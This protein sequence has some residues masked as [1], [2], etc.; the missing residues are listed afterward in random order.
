MFTS[1][2]DSPPKALVYLRE[3]ALVAHLDGNGVLVNHL[4]AIALD[5]TRK[6]YESKVLPPVSS[7]AW[8]VV[9]SLFWLTDDYM[10]REI[11]KTLKDVEG[12]TKADNELLKLLRVYDWLVRQPLDFD[13]DRQTSDLRDISLEWAGEKNAVELEVLLAHVVELLWYRSPFGDW[14]QIATK[15][16]EGTFEGLANR[17]HAL[18]RRLEIQTSFAV[19]GAPAAKDLTV[20]TNW[21]IAPWVPTLWESVFDCNFAGIEATL[22]T[23]SPRYSANTPSARLLFD[24]R[25]Y[26]RL[27]G[28]FGDPQSIGLTRRRLIT[29]ASPELVFQDIREN[30]ARR[31]IAELLSGT[32]HASDRFFGFT[33]VMLLELNSLRRWDFTAWCEAVE[34]RARLNADVVAREAESVE[35]ADVAVR[36]AITALRFNEND[37]WIKPVLVRLEFL[38]Q[39]ALTT[40]IRDLTHSRPVHFHR[41]RKIIG[42]VGDAIPSDLYTEVAGWTLKYVEHATHVDVLGG[43]AE[44]VDFL[45]PLLDVIPENHEAWTM[46]WPI[47]GELFKKPILWQV[48]HGDFLRRI[49]DNAP[50]HLAEKGLRFM[51]TT[52]GDKGDRQ[53]RWRLVRD[54]V[55]KR[56]ALGLSFGKK[57]VSTAPTPED[58][59]CV[60]DEEWAKPHVNVDEDS[61]R[62]KALA[63]LDTL[64]KQS[65][66]EEGQKKFSM[67]PFGWEAMFHVRW[68]TV[69]QAAVGKLIDTINHPRVLSSHLD[70]LLGYLRSMVERGPESFAK[71][72]IPQVLS[73]LKAP[74]F[75][76]DPMS[77]FTGVFSA[78]VHRSTAQPRIVEELAI[79]AATIR[80]KSNSDVDVALEDY[81]LRIAAFPPPGITGAAVRLILDLAIDHPEHRSELLSAC[82]AVLLAAQLRAA[83][84][85]AASEELMDGFRYPTFLFSPFRECLVDS[86]IALEL[87][88]RIEALVDTIARTGSARVRGQ[89][90]AFL[91]ALKARDAITPQLEDIRSSLAKDPRVSVRRFA[92]SEDD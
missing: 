9:F 92:K 86:D 41:V 42:V 28:V 61:V 36:N 35:F 73:W 23:E 53:A 85:V 91:S 4:A 59:V 1:T 46:L 58:L 80:A 51:L 6:S 56:P 39:P 84:D 11:E 60:R 25:H 83:T 48:G 24:L 14:T 62:H 78:F 49:L 18:I 89:L 7:W 63:H 65:V 66:M 22:Q 27:R 88:C 54:A 52:N 82:Q 75:G 3:Q 10:L 68:R 79:M 5:E 40:L 29:T 87:G 26:N 33:L 31:I 37:S 30:R 55:A 70:L 8:S 64:L 69:D 44:K 12:T 13:C 17:L 81:V 50:I 16:A 34:F 90:A 20:D 47:L 72:A 67:A 38:P 15:L 32:G 76:I 43:S 57:I 74:P 45:A 21:D 19:L 71:V 77:D 2:S